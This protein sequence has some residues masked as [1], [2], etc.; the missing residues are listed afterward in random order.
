MPSLPSFLPFSHHSSL[1]RLMR[2]PIITIVKNFDL[3]LYSTSTSLN[4]SLTYFIGYS[5]DVLQTFSEV[6]SSELKCFIQHHS[7]FNFQSYSDTIITCLLSSLQVTLALDALN[8]LSQT[9][10]V[11]EC[12]R[13]FFFPQAS[14]LLF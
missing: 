7:R 2:C 14:K 6:M 5:P 1:K 10:C 13:R 11:I 9:C 3:K 4:L 12:S 8:N